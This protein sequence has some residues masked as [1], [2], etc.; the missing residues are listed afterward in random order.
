MCYATVIIVKSVSVSHDICTYFQVSKSCVKPPLSK[1]PKFGFLDQLSLN[2]SGRN[3]LD[4][5]DRSSDIG[6]DQ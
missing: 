3:R 2:A 5:Y 6:S 4:F 1:R